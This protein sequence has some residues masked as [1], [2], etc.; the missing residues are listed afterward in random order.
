MNETRA[1]DSRR[2]SGRFA[3]CVYK[4]KRESVIAPLY[5]S[6]LFFGAAFLSARNALFSQMRAFAPC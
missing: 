3:L 6:E 5:G 2:E 1:P 4:V